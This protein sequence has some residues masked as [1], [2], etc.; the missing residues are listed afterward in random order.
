M[1]Q[2]VDNVIKRKHVN[3]KLLITEIYIT[4]R[5]DYMKTIKKVREEYKCPHCHEKNLSFQAENV[6]CWN[7]DADSDIGMKKWD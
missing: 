2:T 3:R 6:H 7:C 4:L 5:E 1:Q